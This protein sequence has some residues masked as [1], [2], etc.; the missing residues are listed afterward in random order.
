MFTLVF[1][2]LVSV[3]SAV[4]WNPNTWFE[5]RGITGNQVAGAGNVLIPTMTSNTAPSGV[6]SASVGSNT[7]WKT[8]DNDQ[9]SFPPIWTVS[10][11]GQPQWIAYQFSNSVSVDSFSITPWSDATHSPSHAQF[12][13][14]NN[15]VWTTAYTIGPG[16]NGGFGTFK[17]SSVVTASNFRLYVIST[18]SN[19]ALNIRTWQ[20]YGG[21]V[22][23]TPPVCTSFTYSAWSACSTSGQQTRTIISNSPN[24]CVGGSPET[25]TQNCIRP[26]TADD[27][28]YTLSPSVCPTNGQ[29]NMTYV[30]KSGLTDCS[31]GA[32]AP[33]NGIMSC[34]YNAPACTDYQVSLFGA[35]SNGYRYR[36]VAGIPTG[37]SGGAVA[38]ST[39]EP[40]SNEIDLCDDADWSYVIVPVGNGLKER[41]WSKIGSCIEGITHSTETL[42]VNAQDLPASCFS[43]TYG[44][45]TPSN[46]VIGSQQTRNALGSSG[47]VQNAQC[48]GGSPILKQNCLEVTQTV[49]N[50]GCSLGDSPVCSNDEITYSNSCNAVASGATVA[51]QGECPC[52]VTNTAPTT[53]IVPTAVPTPTVIVPPVVVNE[54]TT[55]SNTC[56]SGCSLSGKCVPVG[57]RVNGKYCHLDGNLIVYKN[58]DISCENNFECG[59]N[60]CISGKCIDMGV[61]QRIFEYFKKWLE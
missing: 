11:N 31:G 41:R 3:V 49:T 54:G 19:I 52:P 43:F 1:L 8:M 21:A 46:C 9:G 18:P 42:S 60:S 24:G 58:T 55:G 59:S 53:E 5:G 7:A 17:L 13:Y 44:S 25:L 40:C 4:W 15:G 32:V 51:C 20:L 23:N 61:M 56:A 14:L 2:F 39:T 22:V 45:W 29:Q 33:A 12:Q 48:T 27:Y 28:T 37:C 50:T 36:S 57:Y 10:T 47:G 34:T 35:C 16:Y 26:C 30:K 38:P 6:A